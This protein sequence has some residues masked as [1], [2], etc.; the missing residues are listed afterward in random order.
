MWHKEYF[1]RIQNEFW[2][3]ESP[4]L[5]MIKLHVKKSVL[6]S[7]AWLPTALSTE[8]GWEGVKTVINLSN[9]GKGKEL[10][11]RREQLI[12]YFKHKWL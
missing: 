2:W 5:E 12:K 8:Y 7:L 10:P 11:T 1:R 6:S 4:S 3:S 9:G